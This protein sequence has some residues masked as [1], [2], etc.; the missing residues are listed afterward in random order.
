MDHGSATDWGVLH[1]TPWPLEASTQNDDP[2]IPPAETSVTIAPTQQMAT[3]FAESQHA[4]LAAM[5]N[6]ARV[7]TPVLPPPDAVEPHPPQPEPPPARADGDAPAQPAPVILRQAPAGDRPHGAAHPPPD[8]SGRSPA[9]ESQASDELSAIWRSLAG[10]RGLPLMVVITVQAVLSLRLVW[11]NTAFPDEALYLWAGHLEWAHWL[12]GMP[13]PAFNTFFSGAPIVYPPLGAIAD[14]IGGLAG[15]RLL[16]LCF[17]LG[18]TVLLHGVTRR[19]F[20]RRSA[21]FGAAMFAGL[22]ATQYLGAFATYDAMALM[23]LT[24][25]TWLAVRAVT[26]RSSVQIILMIAVACVLALADVTKYAATLFDPIV[27]AVAGLA[28]WRS[29]GRRHGVVTI[30][31]VSCVLCTLLFLGIHLGGPAYSHG[32]ATTTLARASG[33]Y[34]ASFLLFASGKWV[35]LVAIAAILGT[36]ATASN[37][38]GRITTALAGVLTAAVFLVPA[39]QARI[40]T[41]TSLFKHVG[42]GGWFACI[43]AGYAVASLA[44]AVPR[45]KAVQATRVGTAAVCLA[46]LPSVFL[47]VSHFGWPDT[48]QAMPVMRAVLASTLGPVLA[49]DRGN[50]LDY[51]LPTETAHRQ[52]LGTFFFAYNDP[53]TG[54]H[55][56]GSPAYAA[57]IH[58]RYFSVIILEFWDTAQ[59]DGAILH[60]LETSAGYQ[61]V[62]TIPYRATGQHGNILIWVR[63]DRR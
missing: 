25:A 40:H 31:T 59:T 19:I 22:S 52:V 20:D 17:M 8:R 28:V 54:A 24:L 46:A 49:D 37:Q 45:S 56:T 35:G 12:H 14:S 44:W 41:Y 39:E 23:L 61:P 34:S 50:I 48:S 57:A 33:S 4:G 26:C 7:P 5:I 27:I 11:S 13:I 10:V 32:I 47:A 29:R 3:G 9:A 43:P 38:L 53:A 62:A 42:F 1:S 51:Y 30:M 60:D 63:R 2:Q 16:S 58:E 6:L 18:A 15:A 55:L 36:V 21:L